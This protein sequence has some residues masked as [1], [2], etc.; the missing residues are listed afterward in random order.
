MATSRASRRPASAPQALAAALL[1]AGLAAP[2]AAAERRTPVSVDWAVDGS[3][4]A[5][6]LALW[7]GGHL[8]REELAPGECRWCEPPGLDASARDAVLWAHPPDAKAL[9][10]ALV[11]AVPAGVALYDRLMVGSGRAALP[12]LLLVGEAIALSGVAVQ[13][14]KVVAA[15]RRPYA[16]HGTLPGEGVDDDLSFYSSH[17]AIAFSAVAAGGMLA[18]LRGDRAWPWVYGVGFT[19]A[20]ATGYLRMA[21]DRHWLTD[22]LAGAATGTAIGLAVPWLH[23]NGKGPSAVR[24]SI[25]PGG[26]AL[27]GDF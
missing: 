9:S 1:L 22:V 6:A 21:A 27:A 17:T 13:A 11:V 10:D 5:G 23:R 2:A 12:D 3:V 14:T 19:V 24:L 20:G 4:T 15:R 8:A 18:Q 16:V 26:V 25:A 7:L